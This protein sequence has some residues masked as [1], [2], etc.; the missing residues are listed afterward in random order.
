MLKMYKIQMKAMISL[1]EQDNFLNGCLVFLTQYLKYGKR[2]P[3]LL[4]KIYLLLY[5]LLHLE[6]GNKKKAA[7]FLWYKKV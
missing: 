5:T 4:W 3:L 7:V 2:S 1:K 6:E